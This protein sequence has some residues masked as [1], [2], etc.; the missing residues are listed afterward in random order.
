[1]AEQNKQM[2]PIK[3]HFTIFTLLAFLLG[4]KEIHDESAT[5]WT[6]NGSAAEKPSR[7]GQDQADD[8]AG[9]GGEIEF[10]VAVLVGNV[11]G[12]AAQPAKAA[13]GPNPCAKEC[14]EKAEEK[15]RSAEVLHKII[16]GRC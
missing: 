7:E 4:I 3:N 8:D 11:A 10:E 12:Q 1:V 9:G 6:R 13:S 5:F 16:L 14:D 2:E 15:E